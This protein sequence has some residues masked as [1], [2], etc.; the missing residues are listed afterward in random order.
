MGIVLLLSACG[1]SASTSTALATTTAQSASPT[2]TVT[3][4]KPTACSKPVELALSDLQKTYDGVKGL[5]GTA[6]ETEYLIEA[7]IAQSHAE[8]LTQAMSIAEER[9]TL[10]VL[11]AAATFYQDAAAAIEEALEVKNEFDARADA[12]ADLI[13]F[14]FEVSYHELYSAELNADIE[15]WISENCP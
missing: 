13:L 2:V 6:L 10:E 11:A 14:A 3:T 1:S 5:R 7:N 8:T 12:R 9:S 15:A 4:T